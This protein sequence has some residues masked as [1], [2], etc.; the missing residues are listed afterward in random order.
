MVVSTT[1]A[2]FYPNTATVTD[3]GTPPDPNSGNNTYVALA[4]V[5][6]V[7]CS[8]ATLTAGGTL[9]GTVN[10]YY[11]GTASVAKGATSI[12]VG[13][14]TG[15][16]GT[17][18]SGSLL[19]VIQ[20][21][22]ASINISNT[23]AYGNGS[24]GTG[25]MTINNAGNYEFVTATGPVSGGSVP[26]TGAGPGGGL[27]FGYTAAAATATKGISTYQVVLVPQY[28]SATLGALTATAWNGSTGG[29]LALDIAGQL[30][31][32][33]ATVQVDGQG[34]RGGAGMQLVGGVAGA[35]NSD[36]RQKS[37][38]TYTGAAGGATG[39][40]GSKGEGVAGTP[41]WVESGGTFLQTPT[42]YPSGTAG[43][44]G[45]MARGAPG[46]AGGGG[47]DG[48]AAGNTENA[49]GGGGGNGGMGGFGGDSWNVNLSEGGEGGSPFP[50]TIDRIG[51]GG[52]G[53]AGSRN[54]SDTDN[55][56]SAGA[57]GGGIIFIRAYNLT[58]TAT[59]TANGASAYN[60]TA[61]DAGGGGGAGGSALYW[62]PTAGKPG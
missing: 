49:G 23:V 19:L 54:N 44:D 34:F 15:A 11:P 42:G 48:D 14:A 56:A 20:M 17:I 26:I 35:L 61:N 27:V 8:G 51:L 55:Q 39:I 28:L 10:T 52:G 38:T 41:Q 60:G 58:G 32:G 46:N 6:N 33:G 2:G 59:L 25:F 37:P 53:G 29:V 45:S 22:D 16:G 57:A 43:V 50:A 62:R 7:V 1:T 36:Y 13:A 3:S 18:A 12:P 47:T 4:P 31:L 5:V 40:D 24:T 30:N 9:S 21:Q